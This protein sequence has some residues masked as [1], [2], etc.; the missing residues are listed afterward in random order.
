MQG[1]SGTSQYSCGGTCRWTGTRCE[2]NY[3]P[4]DWDTIGDCIGDKANATS[5]KG[6][7]TITDDDCMARIEGAGESAFAKFACRG[8]G[9]YACEWNETEDHARN[10][11]LIRAMNPVHS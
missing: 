9:F 8:G 10:P 6:P 2:G 4:I 5:C 3:K 1:C 7:S 11:A